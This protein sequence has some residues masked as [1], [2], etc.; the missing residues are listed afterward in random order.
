MADRVCVGIALIGSFIR[1]GN[2]F[3]SEIIGRP[4]HGWWAVTFPRVDRIPRHPA[5]LYEAIFYFAVFFLLSRLYYKTTIKNDV[6][7]LFG[8]FL[9]AVFTFRFLIE[10]VKE[11]QVAF[12]KG[13][14]LNM[15]Q[16][17]S[18]PLI[19]IGLALFFKKRN[20]VKATS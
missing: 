17:L 1:I 5:Q 2:L 3:N 14:S 4:T 12:E 6:G 11:D 19:L 10:F 18:V 8:I 13:M 15:G 9:T 20:S 16:I 7:A